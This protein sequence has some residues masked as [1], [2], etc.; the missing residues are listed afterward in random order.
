MHVTKKAMAYLS[1]LALT[2]CGVGY[3]RVL[4]TTRSN[5]GIDLDTEPPTAQIAISRTEGVFEPTFED[6][7]TLPVSA[8][9]SSTQSGLTSFF[10]GVSSTI[11]TGEAATAITALYN[12][13]DAKYKGGDNQGEVTYLSGADPRKIE[14]SAYDGEELDNRPQ[15]KSLF[16]K[17]KD[18]DLVEPGLTKPV[19]FGTDTS[20]GLK[21]GWSNPTSPAPSSVKL[22]FNRKELAWA[23]VSIRPLGN[24]TVPGAPPIPPQ[25][26]RVN[27]PSLLATLDM[28]AGASSA[29]EGTNLKWLQYFATGRAATNLALRQDVRRAM[30]RRSDPANAAA[31][32]PLVGKEDTKTVAFILLNPMYVKLKELAHDNTEAAQLVTRM[33]FLKPAGLTV[34]YP[35]Y[36][37][38][39][40]QKDV[41]VPASAPLVGTGFE[42]LHSYY[43]RLA[44]SITT[45]EGILA[46]PD[47]DIAKS[48][49]TVITDKPRFKRGLVEGLG[50]MNDTLGDFEAGVLKNATVLNDV[51]SFFF[52]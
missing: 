34:N 43:T 40:S 21:V 22:G 24:P 6:G 51:V 46:L 25:K 49:G 1:L 41:Q 27:I 12:V 10:V 17:K 3:N 5:V 35:E 15:R 45:V 48:N 4:F 38:S 16:G 36:R 31:F 37:Y 11:A 13:E 30:L 39:S 7:K 18:I 9:F 47:S 26:Y 29:A 2:G 44:L 14:F 50:Q 19:F 28:N 32:V 52:R 23:P 33:N 8:S 20:F 42:Q